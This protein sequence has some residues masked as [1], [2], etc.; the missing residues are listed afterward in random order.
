MDCY[1][2]PA[3]PLPL[4]LPVECVADIVEAPTVTALKEARA[5]WMV[6]SL[7]WENQRVS[8]LSFSALCSPTV[9]QTDTE[10]VGSIVVLNPVP[11]AARQSYSGL[12]CYS[13]VSKVVVNEQ[14]EFVDMPDEVDRRYAEAA[15][16][17]DDQTYIIPK[18]SA[19]AVAFSYF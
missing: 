12:A 16:S 18:L 11:G 17:F 14:M 7:V 6:G 4:L 10:Q 9:E 5:D 3:L 1:Q 2:I 15:V 8:L 13:S 19:L